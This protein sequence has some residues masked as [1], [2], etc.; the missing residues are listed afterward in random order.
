MAKTGPSQRVLR[1][2]A[3]EPVTT[4]SMEAVRRLP[5]VQR[6]RCGSAGEGSLEGGQEVCYARRAVELTR[7]SGHRGGGGSGRA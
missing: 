6:P 7:A 5:V 3:P 4:H 1:V 2:S